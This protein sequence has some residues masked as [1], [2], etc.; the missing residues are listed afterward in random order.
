MTVYVRRDTCGLCDQRVFWNSETKVLT[1][2]CGQ[3]PARFVNL[4]EFVKV[5]APAIWKGAATRRMF[6]EA[7]RFV[8]GKEA[9][10]DSKKV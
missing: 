4:S 5:A 6:P 1:C 7:F 3:F 9:V 2:G 8:N 10:V